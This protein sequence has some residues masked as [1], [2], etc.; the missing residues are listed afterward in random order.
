M[1][2]RHNP[3]TV[4][5]SN[6]YSHGVEVPPRTRVLYISGQIGRARDG[7]IPENFAA[8]IDIA[9]VNLLEVLASAG[10]GV[11]DLVKVNEFLTRPEDVA[12]CR[13]K[14]AAIFGDHRPATTLCVVQQLAYPRLLVEI[15][16]V[17]ARSA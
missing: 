12:E 9:W 17:A 14:R 11:A 6:A 7:S 2:R 8:Q 10:M 5:P 15:D 16:A 1:L 13:A 4:C 3:D